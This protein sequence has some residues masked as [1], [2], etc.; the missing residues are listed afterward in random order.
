MIFVLIWPSLVLSTAAF[1]SF[2]WAL[3]GHFKI[4]G[5]LPTG[6]I[7]LSAASLLSYACYVVLLCNEQPRLP[8]LIAEWLLV[9]ASLAIF[10]WA[11]LA[12][13]AAAFCV[14]HSPGMPSFF[15]KGG[16]YRYVRHPFYLAYI[17]FWIATA[18]A[19][20]AWQWLW[21]AGLSVWYVSVARQEEQRF[22][23]SLHSAAYARYRAQVG[24]IVP[25]MIF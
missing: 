23:K 19:A 21:A 7:L 6:M 10:W 24:M 5:R 13:R 3:R 17:I 20:G 18:V 12:T 9:A 22:A 16:P 4:S 11:I 14:A 25:R 8:S 15:F 1:G 2:S